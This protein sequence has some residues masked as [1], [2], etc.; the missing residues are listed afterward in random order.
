MI[1]CDCQ[2][3]NTC[4]CCRTYDHC[5]QK[6]FIEK[7]RIRAGSSLTTII[8]AIIILSVIFIKLI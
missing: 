1:T 5:L 7:G 2:D 6:E 4:I 3:Y 8:V